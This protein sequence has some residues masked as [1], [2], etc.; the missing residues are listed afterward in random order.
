MAS[1]ITPELEPYDPQG[2]SNTP[3]PA[4]IQP[5]RKEPLTVTSDADGR[6]TDGEDLGSFLDEAGK[7]EE[8]R[9]RGEEPEKPKKPDRRQREPK[10]Q[11]KGE[12]EL[13]VDPKPEKEPETKPEPEQKPEAKTDEEVPSEMMKVLPNDKPMTARRIQQFLKTIEFKDKTVAEKDAIIKQLQEKTST[14]GGDE[15]LAKIKADLDAKSS[16]LLKYRRRYE[17]DTDPEIKSKFD[18][19]VTQAEGSI[20]ETLAKH[21]LGDSTWKE[22]EKHGGFAAF[23]RSSVTYPVK[24]YN[25]DGQEVIVH[26]TAAQLAKS[27]LEAMPVGDTEEVRAALGRQS[28]TKAE[29]KRF[30]EKETAEA[31]KYFKS[32]EEQRSRSQQEQAASH[33]KL[34]KEFG[35]WTDNE[36][37]TKDWLKNKDIPPG[38]TSDQKK[39]VEEENA[40]RAQL[41]TMLKNPPTNSPE[42]VREVLLGGVEAHYLRKEN[43]NLASRVKALE[44]ELSK[45]KGGTR[46]TPKEG[47]LLS[48][49]RKPD[50]N[51]KNKY[52]VDIGDAFESAVNARIGGDDSESL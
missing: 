33:E 19:P 20:K 6:K 11:P 23:S 22:I 32:Q 38:A 45:I 28:M 42:K 21:G 24:E 34:M 26:K 4:V 5:E 43:G 12:E 49:A 13:S 31:D 8:A 36:I 9:A 37:K 14:A 17:L 10:I 40:F 44:A 18:E 48:S 27:W 1:L 2:S 25:A 51:P 39:Q 7:M 47:S 16:E 3:P 30:V 46:T 15:E 29:K 41:R 35:E 52:N 50:A